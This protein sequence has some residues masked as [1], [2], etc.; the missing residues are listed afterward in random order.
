MLEMPA[1]WK[2]VACEPVCRHTNQV[3]RTGAR[4]QACG[5]VTGEIPLAKCAH[6]HTS[7]HHHQAHTQPS[8]HCIPAPCRNPASQHSRCSAQ[9]RARGIARA[10]RPT[11]TRATRHATSQ[12]RVRKQRQ[13]AMKGGAHLAFC[14][15]ELLDTFQPRELR[16]LTPSPTHTELAPPLGAMRLYNLLR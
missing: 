1:E 10:Q 16:Y 14:E 5:C 15:R 6:T 12:H 3:Q 8:Q 4:E 7:K 13:P 11:P 2:V 9:A